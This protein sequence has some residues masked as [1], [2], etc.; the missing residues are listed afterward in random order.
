MNFGEL[1]VALLE[2]I[3][4]APSDLAYSLVTADINKY[5]RVEEMISSTTLTEAASI[6]LPADFLAVSSVYID[7]DPRRALSPTSKQAM[8]SRHSNGSPSVYAIDGGTMYLS[9]EPT[10]SETVAL[11][12]YA[13]VAALS[14]DADTNDVLTNYPD[15]YVYGTL[16]HHAALI[17]DPEAA[18]IWRTG[19]DA[20]IA[21]AN[22]NARSA[23]Y[24]G[25]PLRVSVGTAP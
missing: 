17:R 11:D 5:L 21:S 10:T 3:G 19:Y 18:A 8:N 1:K 7:T 12:Y 14:A 16:T 6:T 25:A 2:Q 24:S 9:P 20:A 22:K 13:R 15:V 4:R 23:K